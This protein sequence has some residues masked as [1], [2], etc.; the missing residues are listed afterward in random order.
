MNSIAPDKPAGC[1]YAG[2]VGIVGQPSAV[3]LGPSPTIQCVWTSVVFGV[4]HA[5]IGFDATQSLGR[6]TFGRLPMLLQNNGHHRKRLGNFLQLVASCFRL[7]IYPAL[8][9]RPVAA[10]AAGSLALYLRRLRW[11]DLVLE[12]HCL[13]VVVV[14]AAIDCEGRRRRR[15]LS[16]QLAAGRPFASGSF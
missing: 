3:C 8:V 11:L 7:A 1:S 9:R 12:Q 4:D 14:V 10:A 2:V 13:P 16:L 15:R 6:P 5:T